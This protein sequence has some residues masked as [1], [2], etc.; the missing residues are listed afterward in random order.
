[1]TK[2][3][4]WSEKEIN[5]LKRLVHD[6]GGNCTKI[7][8]YFEKRSTTSIYKKLLKMFKKREISTKPF[9]G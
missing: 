7:S 5:L 6:I 8:N 2:K 1:M 4:S 3:C 9:L